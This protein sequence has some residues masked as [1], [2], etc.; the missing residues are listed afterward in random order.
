MLDSTGHITSWNRGA[1]NIKGYAAN[2]IIGTHFSVFYPQHDVDAGKCEYELEQAALTGRFEDE[3]WRIRKD[4]TRFW[5]NVIISAMRDDDGSLIGFSK[6][7]RDLTERR[8][9]EEEKAARYAAEQSNRAKDEFLAM[10]GHELR[11]PLAP[12]VTA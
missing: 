6:V 9:A 8:R 7:T 11:N 2:E 10:L 1:E 4:G 12:I 3:G 5:A